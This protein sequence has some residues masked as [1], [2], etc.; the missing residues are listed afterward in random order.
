M[1]LELEAVSHVM[2]TIGWLVGWLRQEI[3]HLS[4]IQVFST[5]PSATIKIISIEK[6]KLCVKMR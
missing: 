6:K 2:E 5:G 1:V 4:P 3:M